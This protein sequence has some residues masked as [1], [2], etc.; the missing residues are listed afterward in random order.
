MDVRRLC[1]LVGSALLVLS[2]LVGWVGIRWWP[3]ICLVGFATLV[4]AAVYPVPQEAG[5]ILAPQLRHRRDDHRILVDDE[6]RQ[7]LSAAVD[8]GERIAETWPALR[9]MV[10]T[11]A[12]ERLLAHALWELA[13]LLE[14]RQGFR[15]MR[16]D[17][18]EH[19][20]EGLP[21][22]SPA[23]RNL[24]AQRTKVA[25]A[26]ADLDAEVGRRLAEL[27]ATAVAGENIIREWE[28][29]E[30]VRDADQRLAELAPHDLPGES[31]AGAALA[32]QTEA[33][34][35]AYRELNTRYGDGI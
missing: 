27:T 6:D 13:D 24:L 2:A 1:R 32:D 14:R 15:E 30:L 7:A 23:V 20:H 12:A 26:L 9:G 34:M 8:L 25:T 18:A 35:A 28:I 16:D 5:T 33:V 29:G 3:A 21:A 11:V 17:L 10:D 31:R 22:D 4:V 19:D